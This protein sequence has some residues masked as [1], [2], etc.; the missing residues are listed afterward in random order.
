M[1][2]HSNHRITL[3]VGGTRFFTS[4]ATLLNEPNSY[5]HALL[6]SGA[7]NPDEAGEYFIDRNPRLF[8]PIL[9]YWRENRR[10][11]W[12][13]LDAT[14]LSCAD[15]CLLADNIAYY[16]VESLFWMVSWVEM[17]HHNCQFEWDWD[18]FSPWDASQPEF[19]GFEVV[20]HTALP[21]LRSV[22]PITVQ[23][24]LNNLRSNDVECDENETDAPKYE[25]LTESL[26]LQISRSGKEI[27]PMAFEGEFQLLR[28]GD[29][30]RI[31]F[32]PKFDGLQKHAPLDFTVEL[33]GVTCRRPACISLDKNKTS[34][35][36]G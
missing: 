35:G 24:S 4:K 8:E 33:A 17:V 20:R 21:L 7:F 18:E 1:A 22:A 15:Q 32:A 13:G 28:P 23:W 19:F 14:S 12:L 2:S 11:G 27:V 10:D 3:N 30:K 34:L 31:A 36:L 5:F 29:R 6:E 26:S 9:D 16:N 25:A